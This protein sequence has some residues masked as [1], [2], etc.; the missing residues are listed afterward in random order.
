[1]VLNCL[2]LTK[3]VGLQEVIRTG[4]RATSVVPEMYADATNALELLARRH[5]DGFVIDCDVVI[6]AADL[7]AQIRNSRSNKMS[8]IVAI[9]NGR[10]SVSMAIDAGTNFVLGKPV[11]DRQLQS[12]LAIALPRMEREHRR[13]GRHKVDLPV[14]FLSQSGEV[15]AGKIMNVSECGIALIPFDS[16]PITGVVTVRFRLSS[17]DRQIFQAKADVVWNDAFAVGLR[18]LRIEPECRSSFTAW[19]NSLEAGLQPGSNS[20][21]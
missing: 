16:S 21:V 6:Q 15:F 2:M 7:L 3:D 13:Y 18:F 9:V 8:V 20:A 11:Q 1:M 10:T 14:E 12:I 4:L 17:V 5:F 19:L